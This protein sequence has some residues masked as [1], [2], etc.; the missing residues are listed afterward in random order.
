MFALTGAKYF[1]K[2]DASSGYW[3]VSLDEQSSYLTCLNT[4]FGRYRYHRLPFGL[5]R[6]GDEYIRRMDQCFEGLD[7]VVSIV[8]VI[9]VSGKSREIMSKIY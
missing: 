8:D 4:E 2:L 1:T 7:G 9:C 5:S 3:S 6:S